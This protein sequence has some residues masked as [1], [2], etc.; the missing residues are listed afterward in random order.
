MG[1]G[2]AGSRPRAAAQ[3][4]GLCLLLGS[5]APGAL[6]LLLTSGRWLIPLGLDAVQN[7]RR[8]SSCTLC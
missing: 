3:M 1:A 2:E 5:W 7:G 6:G 4:S 8:W